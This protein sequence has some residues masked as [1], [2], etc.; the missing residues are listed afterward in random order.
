MKPVPRCEPSIYQPISRLHSHCT[1]T[2]THTSLIAN[3]SATATLPLILTVLS[4]FLH[5]LESSTTCGLVTALSGRIGHG[6]D[7]PL[8]AIPWQV[9]IRGRLD[10][11]RPLSMANSKHLCGATL[12]G[13]Q[14]ILTTAV[15]LFW[16]DLPY[17]V[18]RVCARVCLCVCMCLGR[19]CCVSKV[20][21]PPPPLKFEKCPFY[22]G[23]LGGLFYKFI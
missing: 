2:H 11:T 20:S 22:L 9:S 23:F 5:Y 16:Y 4:L 6:Q 13:S 8:C 21:D 17:T 3:N 18:L 10:Q 19:I 1:I 7:A 14:H 15:C 12:I